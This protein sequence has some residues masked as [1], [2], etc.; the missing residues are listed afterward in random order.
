MY[1]ADIPPSGVT[2]LSLDERLIVEDAWQAMKQGN[3]ARAIKLL[4]QLNVENPF[5]YSGLG[6]AYYVENDLPRAEDYFRAAI[7]QHPDMIL[8]HLGMGQIYQETGREDQ[9]FTEYREV[10][11][12]EPEHPWAKPRYEEIKS[13]KT[14]EALDDGKTL[15]AGGSNEAART[16]Y[17]K[18]LYYSPDSTEA[19]VALAELYLKE[20]SYDDALVHLKA[21]TAN[22][23]D[24]L[25]ILSIYADTLFQSNDNA[26]SLEMYE[27]L[28]ENDPDNQEAQERIATLKNRLGIF[29]LPSQ[30]GAI[31]AADSITREQVAALISVEF[32]DALPDPTRKP[33]II[34]DISTSWASR[35]I[36]KT[37]TLGI[38][39][40]YP[41][42]TFQ[43]QKVVTR[44]QLAEI[45]YRLV[46]QLEKLGYRFI[47]QI[48]PERIQ[49]SDVSPDNFYYRPIVM[50]ISYDI[51]GLELGRK[52]NPELAVTGQE[53][54]RH[55]NLILA[56]IR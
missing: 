6:Y 20:D 49:I 48:P 17:L 23:P 34:I 33:P 7:T 38:L 14:R 26:R 35:H 51:M 9:A 13:R 53:A 45:L 43:P 41:N 24:N 54:V 12:S 42:H 10:L 56:L 29:E 31:P 25:E 52:F 18:A 36:L 40:V 22:E 30:Y 4:T 55:L 32:K 28:L 50:M 39:E 21:A 44:A 8:G 2:G 3:S 27:K 19:H 37:A 5:Y 47:Q 46:T 1:I 15:A 11:K 16:S